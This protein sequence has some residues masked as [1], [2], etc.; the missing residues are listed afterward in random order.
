MY[1]LKASSTDVDWLNKKEQLI[2]RFLSDLEEADVI[3]L[4]NSPLLSDWGVEYGYLVT[5]SWTDNNG[6]Y[7]IEVELDTALEIS[8]FA[9]TWKFTFED[10]YEHFTLY[11]LNII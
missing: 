4:G 10:Y 5:T 6:F 2:D 3:Q 1:N 9:G 8:K 7:I 11:S